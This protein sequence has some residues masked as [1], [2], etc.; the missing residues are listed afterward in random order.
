MLKQGGG[1]LR[2]CLTSQ[3]LMAFWN[4]FC[5]GVPLAQMTTG[6]VVLYDP[7]RMRMSQ[8]RNLSVDQMQ[9]EGAPATL[10]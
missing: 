10:W 2:R 4:T 5:I 7:V 9:R 8:R 3:K 1:G 6:N